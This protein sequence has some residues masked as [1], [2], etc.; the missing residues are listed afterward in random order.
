MEVLKEIIYRKESIEK[1]DKNKEIIKQEDKENI[2]PKDKNKK[3]E[4]NQ[5]KRYK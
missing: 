4:K 3:I 5:F 2:K 1:Y